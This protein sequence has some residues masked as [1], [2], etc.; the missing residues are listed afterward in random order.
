LCQAE[1]VREAAWGCN[2]VGTSVP[3]QDNLLF[4]VIAANKE[5][6]LTAEK[7]VPMFISTMMN[8][9]MLNGL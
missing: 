2:W 6:K 5:F 9:R 3:F 4:V 7:F 1:R 8:V